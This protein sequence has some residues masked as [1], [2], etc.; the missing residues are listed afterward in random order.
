MDI[1]SIAWRRIGV[2]GAI[3]V[4]ALIGDLRVPMSAAAP[5]VAPRP[6]A[7]LRGTEAR[8]NSA[9]VPEEVTDDARLVPAIYAWDPDVQFVYYR[10]VSKWM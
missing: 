10:Q 4:V 8:V 3:A 1:R 9:A 7:E 6:S 2:I 5:P